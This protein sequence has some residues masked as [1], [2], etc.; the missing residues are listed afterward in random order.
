M[1]ALSLFKR[2]S[3]RKMD[4]PKDDFASF[5]IVRKFSWGNEG[6]I[7]VVR[8]KNS[9]HVYDYLEPHRNV[10]RVY[11]CLEVIDEKQSSVLGH[12]IFMEYCTGGDLHDL[13]DRFLAKP[14]LVKDPVLLKHVLVELTDALI[15]LHHGYTRNDT[16]AAYRPP[17]RPWTAV[18]HRDIKPMNIFLRWPSPGFDPLRANLPDIVLGDFGTAAHQHDIATATGTSGNYP[19][20]IRAEMAARHAGATWTPPPSSRPPMTAACDV[21]CL[22]ATLFAMATLQQVPANPP[23]VDEDVFGSLIAECIASCLRAEPEARPSALDLVRGVAQVLRK[24]RDEEVLL[25]TTSQLLHTKTAPQ[26]QRP[27]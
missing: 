27:L 17:P 12:S 15:Y 18:I 19:P 10:V 1:F 16:T 22:A 2:K 7:S 11:K 9:G 14:D 6:P 5:D 26:T 20:E 8:L 23:R 24:E 13:I 25:P 3:K 4:S 21:W